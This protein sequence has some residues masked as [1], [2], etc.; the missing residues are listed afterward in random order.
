MPSG[1]GPDDGR[2]RMYYNVL[3]RQART[4]KFR[5]M[6]AD[7]LDTSNMSRYLKRFR[8]YAKGSPRLWGLHNYGDVNAAARTSPR[9]CCAPSPARSG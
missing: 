2:N 8:R 9:R 3:R 7:V 6:A 5:V 1:A 4:G